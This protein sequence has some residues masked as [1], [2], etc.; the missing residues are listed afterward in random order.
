MLVFDVAGPVT[1]QDVL[2]RPAVPPANLSRFRKDSCSEHEA[3]EKVLD[4]MATSL[5]RAGYRQRLAK[6]YGFYEPLEPALQARCD[7]LPSVSSEA[8]LS[9]DS[10][11]ALAERLKKTSHLKHDLHH[12]RAATDHLPL[13]RDLPSQD[14]PA[15]VLGCLYVL[16]GASPGG[17]MISQGVLATLGITP[18]TGGSSFEGYGAGT[19]KMWQTMRQQLVKGTPDLQSSTKRHRA[20]ITDCDTEPVRTPGCIQAHGALLVLQQSDLSILQ[21]S[22]GEAKLRS[23]LASEPTDRNPIHAF[24]LPEGR[25]PQALDVTLHTLDGLVLVEFEPLG[26]GMVNGVNTTTS[27]PPAKLEDYAIIKK[28]VP[29]LLSA[30]T[31]QQFCQVLAGEG[32]LLSGMD[33]VMVYKFHANHHGEVVAESLRRD[34]PPLLGLHYPA[35]D[36]LRSVMLYWVES[37]RLQNPLAGAH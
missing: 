2:L 20:T 18:A 9:T 14:T 35:E 36:M 12:L 32:S 37:A 6:F 17:R 8:F 30:S 3:V 33:R 13:C 21:E 11:A 23:V 22:G 7:M 27:A 24:T 16:D 5:T 28:T 1:H 10:Y 34:L 25:Q 31:L 29:R 26:I 15:Q 4:L 19:A